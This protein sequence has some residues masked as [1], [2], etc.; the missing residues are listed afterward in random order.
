MLLS[1]QS[2][3]QIV[4]YWESGDASTLHL[5]TRDPHPSSNTPAS[6]YFYANTAARSIPHDTT[7][8]TLL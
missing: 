2:R 4:V 8:D 7:H 3:R 1:Q 6:D 5:H